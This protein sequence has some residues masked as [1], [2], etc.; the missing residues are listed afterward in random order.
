MPLDTT[1]IGL[2]VA[3]VVLAITLIL[4]VRKRKSAEHSA[5]F[6]RVSKAFMSHFLVPDGEG[7]EIHIEYAMLCP[8]G[9][10]IVDV[11]DVAGNIFGSDSMED[12][13]VITGKQR[14]TFSNPQPGL[15]DRT[16]AIKRMVPDV[17]VVGYIAFTEQGAFNKGR[18]TH[19]IG[20]EELIGELK[21]EHNQK[22]A[23]PDAYWPSWEQL[24]NTAVV[25][26]VGKLVE[27]KTDR[28]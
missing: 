27:G 21:T 14:F 4:V 24:R 22:N 1:T 5:R 16:A 11:K 2:T 17:P 3:A 26:Q 15:F 19:V 20:L 12:W 28:P 6:R 7:G 10:V 8:R 13:A 23:A 25:T 9:I 18:P